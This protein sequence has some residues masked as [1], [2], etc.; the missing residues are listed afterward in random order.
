[1]GY[2]RRVGSAECDAGLPREA[3]FKPR[4]PCEKNSKH[5]AEERQIERF[6]ADPLRSQILP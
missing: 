4:A 6:R 5:P 1:M 3:R 2:C